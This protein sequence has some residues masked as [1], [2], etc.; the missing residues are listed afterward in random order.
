ME[1]QVK[2]SVGLSN[3]ANVYEGKG[4]FDV[5]RAWLKLQEYIKANNLRITSLVLYTDHGQT[6]SLPS[7]GR[8]PIERVI[9]RA[10]ATGVS[11]KHAKLIYADKSENMIDLSSDPLL[12]LRQQITDE[13]TGIIFF[14]AN[15]VSLY[16]P[17]QYDSPKMRQ[18]FAFKVKE[19]KFRREA[20]M[21]IPMGG[22]PTQS[23]R[24]AII[25]AVYEHATME[26]WV[27]EDNPKNCW[28]CMV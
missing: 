23:D 14:D 1:T 13:V 2:F 11:L 12:D 15:G 10:N 17:I 24:Y 9:D 7:S 3:G 25:T 22:Q 8:L 28:V 19:Y 26:L 18:F 5:P 21:T 6:F 4:D 27:S 20:G 16:L